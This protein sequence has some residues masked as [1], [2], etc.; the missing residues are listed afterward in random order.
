MLSNPI[1]SFF[2]L[3]AVLCPIVGM[4]WPEAKAI[5]DPLM[6]ESVGLGL[7]AAADGVKKPGAPH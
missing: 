5:C 2:G 6:A 4:F 3:V 1:T 7:I